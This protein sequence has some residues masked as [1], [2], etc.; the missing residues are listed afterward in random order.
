M[1]R[2]FNPFWDLSE[3][4]LCPNDGIRLIAFNPFWDLSK[5]R[6]HI[7]KSNYQYFQSLLG[8]I[9]SHSQH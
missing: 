1:M 5:Q 9:P 2:S 8:F 6:L 3:G 7:S 4:W